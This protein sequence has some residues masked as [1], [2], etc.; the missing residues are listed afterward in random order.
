M[1]WLNFHLYVFK[2]N[3]DFIS[4]LKAPIT[5]TPKEKKYGRA[6]VGSSHA[7]VSTEVGWSLSESLSQS[8]VAFTNQQQNEKSAQSPSL[9]LSSKQ[10][11][12]SILQIN[13]YG[14]K[15]EY[16]LYNT[17]AERNYSLLMDAEINLAK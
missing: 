10:L 15:A 8:P 1:L 4:A 13:F 14:I 16:L 17:S 12:L 11:L 2:C 6:P 5:H 9:A 7:C 3:Y